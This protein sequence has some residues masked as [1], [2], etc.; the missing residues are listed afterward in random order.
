MVMGLPLLLG[1]LMQKQ[2]TSL[3]FQVLVLGV[4]TALLGV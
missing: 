2:K 3:Q 1:A 4:G